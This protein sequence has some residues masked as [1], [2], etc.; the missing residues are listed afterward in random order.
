MSS[1][2]S[3]QEALEYIHSIPKPGPKKDQS[4]MNGYLR[5]LGNPEKELR[6]IHVAGTNGKG[7]TCRFLA[8][9][10][11]DS[12]YKTGLY[13]SP[14]IHDF[15]ERISIN[16][17]WITSEE[18]IR[19]TEKLKNL[20]EIIQEKEHLFPG[21][22][23]F[24]TALA[25][26]YFLDQQCDIVV[27]ETGMGGQLDATNSIGVPELAV[28]THIDKD[29]EQYLGRRLI[30]I[31]HHKLGIVKESGSVVVSPDQR[32]AVKPVIRQW[33]REHRAALFWADTPKDVRVSEKGTEMFYRQQLL[34]L[35]VLG[36]HQAYNAC[37]V[38]SAVEI[39]SQRGWH[40]DLK[41][42]CRSL[43]SVKPDGRVEIV[44]SKPL[45]IIDGGHNLNAVQS[46]LRTVDT[47]HKGRVFVIFGV[48]RD[49]KPSLLLQEIQKKCEGICFV[50]S[51]DR[52]SLPVSELSKLGKKLKCKTWHA[53]SIEEAVKVLSQVAGNEDTILLTGSFYLLE[54]G[55][56][57][58][59]DSKIRWKA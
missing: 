44:G 7:S 16:G 57:F 50:S 54:E 36:I 15:R 31:A 2:R 22:F 13:Q 39:L 34:R 6:F 18:L 23:E 56:K 59:S 14:Y 28:L 9:I 33:C 45:R 25:F 49:K 46:A 30:D 3:E 11:Q 1:I 38:L 29:H 43:E 32:T 5:A 12:G 26:R 17:N 19:E 37:T 24:V 35:S 55:K 52:R 58:L 47:I 4:R 48:M 53:D 21:E 8:K 10:F 27:L 51:K 41:R 42:A 20:T 40:L